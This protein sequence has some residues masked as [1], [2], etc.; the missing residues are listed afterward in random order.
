MIMKTKRGF[1]H[2]IGY[3]NYA[4]NHIRLDLLLILA[5]ARLL[6]YQ[7]W[8]SLALL[9]SK[10]TLLNI[11]KTS[12]KGSVKIFFGQSKIHVRLL[13]FVDLGLMAP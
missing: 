11:V 1:L 4:N 7:N 5:H 6:N 12:M 2:S 8:Y 3:L 9:L 10:T 13:L